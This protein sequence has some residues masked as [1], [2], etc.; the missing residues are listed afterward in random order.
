MN[1]ED[2]LQILQNVI[3]CRIEDEIVNLIF[4]S[5]KIKKRKEILIFLFLVESRKAGSW[6]AKRIASSKEIIKLLWM[7]KSFV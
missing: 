7:K 6:K 5:K 1:L 2:F 4:F 3:K